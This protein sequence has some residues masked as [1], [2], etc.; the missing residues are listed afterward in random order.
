M[1]VIVMIF[2][3]FHRFSCQSEAKKV[4]QSWACSAARPKHKKVHH[5][6]SMYIDFHCLPSVLRDL[7]K[8]PISCTGFSKI[9]NSLPMVFIYLRWFPCLARYFHRCSQ[10]FL[11]LQAFSMGFLWLSLLFVDS[12]SCDQVSIGV[13]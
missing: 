10:N 2:I 5:R 12:I 4:S 9:F 6:K 3:D 13:H 7:H 11:T 8:F 1:F